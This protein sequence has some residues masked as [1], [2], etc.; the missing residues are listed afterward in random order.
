MVQTVTL[1]SGLSHNKLHEC[2]DWYPSSQFFRDKKDPER[3]FIIFSPFQG[4]EK[5]KKVKFFFFKVLQKTRGI[6]D[7]AQPQRLFGCVGLCWV[8]DGFERSRHNKRAA[9]ITTERR[10]WSR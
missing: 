4:W 10:M 2:V 6:Y 5:K 9:K 8:G 1:R 3:D 7:L